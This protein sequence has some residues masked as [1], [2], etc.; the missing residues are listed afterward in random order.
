MDRFKKLIDDNAL[1]SQPATLLSRLPKSLSYTLQPFLVHS[2]ADRFLL[3]KTRHVLVEAIDGFKFAV[4]PND[5]IAREILHFGAYEKRNIDLMRQLTEG[6]RSTFLDVGAN[7]GNH[8]ILLS[9]DFETVAAFEPNP[10]TFE[11]LQANLALNAL[12]NVR[13]FQFGL[14]DRDADLPFRVDPGSNPGASHFLEAAAEGDMKLSVRNGDTVIA[15]NGLSPVSA[16]K[17]DVEGHEEQV[18][19]GLTKTISADQPIVFFEWDG[20]RNG[21]GCFDRLDGYRFF[22]QPWEL[23]GGRWWRPFARG[24]D[25]AGTPKLTEI[26]YQ[27]VRRRFVSMIAALPAKMA[28]RASPLLR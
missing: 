7:L 25:A 11:R 17:I 26:T 4:D 13:P 22:A 24:L 21:R 19:A 14:S 20:S 23:A 6:D 28:D 2:G 3:P 10:P 18:I 1:I 15:D 5:E 12:S 27:T 9:R 16:I 8:S